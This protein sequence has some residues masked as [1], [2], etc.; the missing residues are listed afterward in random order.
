[1]TLA[2]WLLRTARATPDAPALFQ[3]TE[4]VADYATFARWSLSLCAALQTR[5]RIAQGD[6]VVLAMSNCVE[7]LPIQYAIW[8][9]GAVAVPV[10][11]KLHPK[12]IVW[13]A[14]DTGA[15]LAFVTPDLMAD[16]GPGLNFCASVRDVIT[17]DRQLLSGLGQSETQ[18]G[19][20][21]PTDLA[22][23]FY[24]S[25]TTGRP[26]GVMLSHANLAAMTACYFMDVDAAE[27][28]DTAIYAA[29]L[30][31][32]AGLYHLPHILKGGRHVIPA[33]GRFEAGEILELSAHHRNAVM[34][35]APTMVRR[36]AH[37]AE[38]RNT[39]GVGIK[40]IVYGGAPMYRADIEHA[41]GV[42][43]QRF[44]QIY[45]QGESPMTI[46]A[47]GRSLHGDRSHPRWQ[48]RL[49]SVGQAQSLIEI[50]IADAEGRALPTGE[51]GEVCAKGP[52]VMSGY[53]NRPDA[54]AETLRDGWLHTGDI[55]S[56]DADGFLTLRDRSKDVIISGGSNIY[57]REVEEVLLLHPGVAE[58]AVIGMPNQDW[59]E[60]AVACIAVRPGAS[61]DIAELDRLCLDNIARFKRP[62]RYLMF[63]A[64]PKSNYGKILKTELRKRAAE[65]QS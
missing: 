21:S 15:A 4:L 10:N 30:S 16:V 56:L 24:T 43:G 28:T 42:M 65:D 32:G 31:H 64:L 2:S 55:G 13:I 63:D 38:A 60:E 61:V 41:M 17:A 8:L 29:P 27:A 9:A 40:T 25:G 23:L 11:P 36:L 46:S 49:S 62:K 58:A 26:K 37:E 47:L 19:L 3:G 50:K 57:P 22:W 53:W 5:Y 45:G 35:L 59:G 20:G 54:T 52:S 39:P 33:S 18:T 12:E 48:E 1:M 44:V 7:Y 34:F 6:R 14:D 51:I